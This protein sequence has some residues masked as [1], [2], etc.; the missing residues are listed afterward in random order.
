MLLHT[1]LQL[2]QDRRDQPSAQP[3]GGR[4]QLLQRQR[5]SPVQIPSVTPA[6]LQPPSAAVFR[7]PGAKAAN[8]SLLQGDLCFQRGSSGEEYCVR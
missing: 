1:L 2:G 6:D 8:G 3:G 5:Q 4:E 7:Q